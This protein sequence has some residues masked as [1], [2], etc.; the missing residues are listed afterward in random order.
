M[1]VIFTELLSQLSGVR[2]SSGLGPGAAASGSA[3]T[4]QQNNTSS[5][6]QQLQVQLQLER[7]QA[8]VIA[9]TA[10]DYKLFDMSLSALKA[11]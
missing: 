8:Q 2:R 1:H 4:A 9:T 10:A 5:Q 6:L 7:Q 11:A 3:G